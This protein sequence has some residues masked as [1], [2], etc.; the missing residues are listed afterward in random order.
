M[1]VYIIYRENLIKVKVCKK[2]QC[3]MM[4]GSINEIVRV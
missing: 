3:F 1:Y 2:I 4:H